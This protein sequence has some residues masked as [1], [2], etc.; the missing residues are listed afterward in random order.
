[1]RNRLIVTFAIL[2]VVSCTGG[3]RAAESEA[4]APAETSTATPK[5]STA[6]ALASLPE[7]SRAPFGAMMAGYGSI[8]TAL[9][10]DETTGIDTA[11]LAVAGAARLLETASAGPAKTHYAAIAT[12]AGNVAVS[13]TDIVKARQSFGELSKAVITLLVANPELAKGRVV[14]E[15]PMTS[16]YKK[17]VQSDDTIRNPHY[18]S[19]MLECGT[20]SKLEL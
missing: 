14:V 10:S 11:A 13:A 12:E 16:N 9:A 20:V 2:M 15:C 17:W 18:G 5:T 8:Q 6:D 19:T 1:M 7:T 3:E 4:A